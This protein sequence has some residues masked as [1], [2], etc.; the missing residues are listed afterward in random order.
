M[1]SREEEG[2]ERKLVMRVRRSVKRAR[3]VTVDWA[4]KEEERTM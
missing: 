2:W 1:V 4:M 3:W